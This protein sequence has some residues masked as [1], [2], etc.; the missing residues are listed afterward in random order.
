MK[1]GNTANKIRAI[2]NVIRNGE[3]INGRDIATRL[4]KQGYVVDEAHV[5]M[6]IY[7]YMLYKHLGRERV[8]GI[9]YYYLNGLS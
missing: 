7:H 1:F 5:N 3:K 4:S 2:I 8:K 6:F 9:N